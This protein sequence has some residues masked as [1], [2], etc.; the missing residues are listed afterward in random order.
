MPEPE[1]LHFRFASA[2][3]VPTLVPMIN[4]AFAVETFL[5]STRTD[6]TRLSAQLQQGRILV[7]ENETATILASIYLEPRDDR[8]YLGMLAV[9]PAHQRH[10]LGRRLLLAAENL[11]RSEGFRALEITVLNLRTELPP[12]YRSFGFVETGTEP[13]HSSQPVKPGHDCHC[14]VM[15]KQI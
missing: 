13:F 9:A 7:A 2:A 8:A 4:S 11:L 10:G 15:T 12:I 1:P 5:D 6:A 14:I 3:D